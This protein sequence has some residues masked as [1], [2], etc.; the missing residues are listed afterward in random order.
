MVKLDVISPSLQSILDNLEI[1]PAYVLDHCSIVLAQNR[2]ASVIFG[3]W[4]QSCKYRSSD[5][6]AIAEGVFEF[7][8]PEFGY[9][10]LAH[11]SFMVSGTKDFTL[12]VYIP[13]AGIDNKLRQILKNYST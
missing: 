4:S 11:L 3:N 10:K 1:C 7:N 9:L 12:E 6:K 2:A 8:H 5:D 13:L